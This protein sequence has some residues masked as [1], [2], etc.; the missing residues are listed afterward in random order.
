MTSDR[1]HMEEPEDAYVWIWLPGTTE[2]VVAGRLTR[3]G[4][5]LIFNYGQSYLGRHDRIPV[6][7]PELP[8]RIGSIAPQVGLSMAG[9]LR[10]AAPDAWGRRVILNR[11]FG[12]K[13]KDVD[14]ATLDELAY[15][16][17]SGSDRIGA[18][19]FQDSP[20]EYVPRSARAATLEELLSAAERGRKRCV[21][22]AR[23]R[24][25]DVPRHVAR[26]RPP[27]GDDRGWR[28]KAD[29]Q[30]PIFD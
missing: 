13:G 8:L 3:D 17:Q 29:R 11:N 19:D 4:Q 12:R 2:P 14:T 28:H 23:S 6:Y 16:L 27:Q 22:D 5:R 26:W 18:L 20:A 9:C 7:E 10:D 1:R 21:A 25:G 30:V 24:S 15:L